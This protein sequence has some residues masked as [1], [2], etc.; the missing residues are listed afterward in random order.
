M[1]ID[2]E[3]IQRSSSKKAEE[4]GQ[5]L[6][7]L[8]IELPELR[9][10]VVK[11]ASDSNGIMDILVHGVAQ[12]PE[13]QALETIALSNIPANATNT[14]KTLPDTLRCTTQEPAPLYPKQDPSVIML[15]NP[16]P[17]NLSLNILRWK[18]D[19]VIKWFAWKN[20]YQCKEDAYHAASSLRRAT[21]AWNYVKVGVTFKEVKTA[22]EA[23]FILFYGGDKGT[24]LAKAYFPNNRKPNPVRV[25]CHIFQ[26]DWKENLWKVFTYE[27]GHVLG[28]RHE[29]AMDDG[30]RF[31]GN[32]VQLGMRNHLSVMNYRGS[33]PPEIQQSDIDGTKL[34]YSLPTDTRF[35]QSPLWILC[36]SNYWVRPMNHSW[37]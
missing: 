12:D 1:H 30:P 3:E 5:T 8:G 28:L 20:G 37:T 6:E 4:F 33:A 24:Q 9:E 23:N 18:Y 10:R 27:L 14:T 35:S 17:L 2:D 22:E 29:F 36:L 25:Y 34:F 16:E 11:V 13:P 32:A 21:D 7:T 15:G 31:E 19:S 26:P